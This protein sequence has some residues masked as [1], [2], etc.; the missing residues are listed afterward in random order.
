MNTSAPG[1]VWAVT[2]ERDVGGAAGAGEAETA[3]AGFS[4]PARQVWRAA[5][6]F[7]VPFLAAVAG[8]VWL[9]RSL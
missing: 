2:G 6:A 8:L 1:P 4:A 9:I 5:A 7:A 3:L